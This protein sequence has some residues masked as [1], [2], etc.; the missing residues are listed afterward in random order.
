[1]NICVEFANFVSLMVLLQEDSVGNFQDLGTLLIAGVIAA[2]AVAIAFTFVRLRLRDKKPQQSSFTT[3][4][5][6]RDEE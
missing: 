1:M 2:V 6:Q 3:I 5:S 4:G